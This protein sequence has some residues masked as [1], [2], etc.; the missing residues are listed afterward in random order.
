MKYK[1][2]GRAGFSSLTSA[3]YSMSS[4][5]SAFSCCNR[6]DVPMQVFDLVRGSIP[7]FKARF[8]DA[9]W[10]M[11]TSIDGSG[12]ISDPSSDITKLLKFEIYQ[13]DYA[14][15]NRT[16]QKKMIFVWDHV[17][18][19]KDQRMEVFFAWFCPFYDFRILF[20]ISGWLFECSIYKTLS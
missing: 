10:V 14:W 15:I 9:L 20:E 2:A 8:F 17:R 13:I 1:G 5:D 7:R 19:T 12:G 3:K 6:R 4:S 16:G 18:H 11:R